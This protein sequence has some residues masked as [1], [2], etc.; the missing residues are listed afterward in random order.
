MMRKFKF[1]LIIVVMIATMMLVYGLVNHYSNSQPVS[2]SA[3]LNFPPREL[4]HLETQAKA[5]DCASAYQL[6]RHHSSFTLNSNE[7]VRWFRVAVKC[8]GVS[9][10]Q[11]LIALLLGGQDKASRQE[12][13]R[14]V[15]EILAADPDEGRRSQAA[16]Q[17]SRRRAASS[18]P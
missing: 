5:G 3:E 17:E 11:E 8:P 7:A 1:V 13:D 12:V 2:P 16:V 10:R 18:S 14:L 4:A 6:A 9:P 15:L